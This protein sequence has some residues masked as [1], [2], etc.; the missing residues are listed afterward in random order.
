[1]PCERLRPPD[2]TRRGSAAHFRPG[3]GAGRPTDGRG[4][5]WPR[6]QPDRR[7]SGAVGRRRYPIGRAVG[8]R[9]G[10]VVTRPVCCRV[11][12]AA[13][14][15]LHRRR[16]RRDPFRTEPATNHA[17]GFITSIEGET[18]GQT[19]KRR[20]TETQ[21]IL[22]T[23]YPVWTPNP[24]TGRGVPGAPFLDLSGR[25]PIDSRIPLNPISR[26]RNPR[27]VRVPT[28]ISLC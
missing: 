10:E 16:D 9:R 11:V 20:R 28:R 13:Q 7:H 18:A 23:R 8:R 27:N 24:V 14:A 4:A 6:P 12:R 3:V 15:G 5:G 17:A 2:G 19:M 21:M 1:M 26:P 22:G 25:A